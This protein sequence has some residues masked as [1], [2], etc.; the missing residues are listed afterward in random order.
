MEPDFVACKHKGKD[1]TDLSLINTFAIAFS[2]MCCNL[3]HY[4]LASVC[5]RVDRFQCW[6]VKETETSK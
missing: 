5:I 3:T 1:Q 4:V 6:M 2:R